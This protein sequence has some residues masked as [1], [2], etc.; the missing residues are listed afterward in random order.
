VDT[1]FL[2]RRGNKIPMEGVAET[3]FGAE[4]EWSTILRL[5]Y[6]GIHPINSHQ[7][8]TLLLIPTRFCWQDPD[9]SVF[10]EAM[11]VP[12]KYRSGYTQS[13]IWSNTGSP[14]KE[15]MKI[16]IELKGSATHI[17]GTTIWTNRYPQISCL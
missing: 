9:I 5:P 2:L 17:G 6:P 13:S 15:L 10:C 8:E 3:K 1:S 16:L 4:P 7:T 11:A 12:G 14:M